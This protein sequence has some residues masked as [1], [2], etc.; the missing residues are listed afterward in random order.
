MLQLEGKEQR[1]VAILSSEQR[2]IPRDV[3]YQVLGDQSCVFITEL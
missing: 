3:F 2:Q 1:F